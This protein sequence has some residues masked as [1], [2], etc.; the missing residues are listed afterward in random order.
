MSRGIRGEEMIISEG[1]MRIVIK[2]RRDGL[3]ALGRVARTAAEINE[4]ERGGGVWWVRTRE[5]MFQGTAG[6]VEVP[7][8]RVSRSSIGFAERVDKWG[9]NYIYA[10]LVREE[11]GV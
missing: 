2:A 8:R 4:E 6:R 11:A 5:E 1:A 3:E 7:G 9:D 10:E